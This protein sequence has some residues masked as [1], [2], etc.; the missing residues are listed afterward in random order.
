MTDN[1]FGK[2]FHFL[3]FLLQFFY[4][5][6]ILFYAFNIGGSYDLNEQI[7]FGNR[8]FESGDLSYSSGEND[9]YKPSSPYFPGVGF[10]ALLTRELGVSNFILQNSLML[11][12]AVLLGFLTYI[13]LVRI[14]SNLY[15]ESKI[16]LQSFLLLFLLIIGMTSYKY[17]FAVFKPDSL[18][19]ICS[20]SLFLLIPSSK[21]LDKKKVMLAFVILLFSSFFKQSSFICYLFAIILIITNKYTDHNIK[22]FVVAIIIALGASSLF[23]M[24]GYIDNLYYYTIEVMGKHGFQSASKILKEVQ[25]GVITNSLLMVLLLIALFINNRGIINFKSIDHKL[26]FFF[27]FTWVG[28]SFLSLIKTG[29]NVG[30]FEVGLFVLMPYAVR[31]IDLITNKLND[32]V[33]FRSSILFILLFLNILTFGYLVQKAYQFSHKMEQTKLVINYL[34]TRFP[35]KNVLI[36]GD[37]YPVSREAQLK[38]AGEL[39]TIGHFGKVLGGE[40]HFKKLKFAIKDHHFDLIIG[41]D[42]DLYYK[43]IFNDPEVINLIDQNYMPL[44][45]PN[46]PN[47]LRGKVLVLRD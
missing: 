39:E 20:F 43:T 25:T 38:I 33:R 41:D 21:T 29:G 28:F 13:F 26:Y 30:N 24:F 40:Y 35:K 15:G 12:L 42:I 8:I 9:L 19:L 18:L 5:T 14:Y 34:N 16:K 4:F 47:S 2:L 45:E 11:T 37:Y 31:V 6:A 22:L 27:A 46:M 36:R 23:F 1:K 44:I 32:D 10:L 7:A 3:L 17:Y